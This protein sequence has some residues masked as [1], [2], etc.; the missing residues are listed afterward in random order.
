MTGVF[1]VG[2]WRLLV[3]KGLLLRDPPTNVPC[4]LQEAVSV[5]APFTDNGWSCFVLSYQP[6]LSDVSKPESLGFFGF[7]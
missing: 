5:N 1:V 2:H 3:R 7:S 4:A 6:L